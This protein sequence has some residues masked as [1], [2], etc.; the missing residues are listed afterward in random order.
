MSQT[1]RKPRPIPA[2][3]TEALLHAAALAHLARYAVTQAGLVRVLDRRIDRWG[4]SE[5][6]PEPEQIVAARAAARRVAERLVE[7]GLVNDIEFAESRARNLTR[8]G[9]SRRA[10]AAH[11]AMRGAV[12]PPQEPQT[13]LAA[14]IVFTRRRRIGPFRRPGAEADPHRELGALARAGFDRDVAV[15][16]LRMDKDTAEILIHQLRQD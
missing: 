2:I 10:V 3:P 7:S 12:A 9:R 6:A 1:R 13:E 5:T 11:L 14:A 8:A 16:A 15:K 4:R